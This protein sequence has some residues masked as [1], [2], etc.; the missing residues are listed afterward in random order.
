MT[1]HTVESTQQTVR[2]GFLDPSAP[3]VARIESGDVVSYPNTWTHWGNEAVYGM[4]F[5]EREPLRHRYPNGPYSMLGPVEVNGAEPGDV[6]E[7]TL[8]SLRTRDWGWNS[9]P[10]GVGALPADFPAPYLHYFRF[11]DAR[12]STEYV[13]GIRLPL[14]PFLGVMAVEPVGNAAVSAILAGRHGGNLVLRELTVGSSLYLP[15]AKAGARLWIGDVHALQ[16]D[17]VVDQTA[18]ETAAEDLTIRYELR[19]NV[20]LSAPL[21][22]TPTDWVGLGFA[23]SL[24]DALV[25]CL[26]TLIEWLH[27]AAG[28]A[29]SEAYAFCSMAV[30]FRIT[31]Y[32]HQTGSA[33]SATPPKTVHGLIPKAVFPRS[34]QDQIGAWLRPPPQAAR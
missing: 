14:A 2:S 32:A 27:T 21:A 16:G 9:F 18:I 7:C 12:T 15:V 4:S 28:M 3:P 31:Q 33:Y 30:S 10:L 29:Q 26:R 13:Q 8:L 1:L 19:K 34:V 6:V 25:A 17:G 23:D 5:A 11:D 22:E 20:A 24:D